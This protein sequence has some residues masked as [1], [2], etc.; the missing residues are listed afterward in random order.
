MSIMFTPIARLDRISMENLTDLHCAVMHTLL[1]DLGREVV[2]RYYQIAQKD[3]SVLGLC[4]VSPNG[5]IDAWALGSSNPAE[6][7][8]RLR[9]PVGWF[10]GQ[11]LKLVLK[12]PRV[13]LDLLG[14][15]FSNQEANLLIPG[16]IELTYIGVAGHA[17]GKGLGKTMLTAFCQAARQGGYTSIVLSV[18]TDNPAAR[19]L[20]T[21]SGFKI[22]RTFH[23]GRFERHRMV[24]ELKNQP[25]PASLHQ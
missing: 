20:Y 8:A 9:Q 7:N 4:A 5:E 21:K 13:M 24:L 15:S 3:A 25:E 2:Q 23:E 19:R 14:S 18:E 12:H 11:M 10:A 16:Q 17:Q 22:T 6:L 1:A